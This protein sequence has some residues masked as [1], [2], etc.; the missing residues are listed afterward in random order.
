MKS[1]RLKQIISMALCAIIISGFGGFKVIKTN[2][3]ELTNIDLVYSNAY[4]ATMKAQEDNT[5]K[6]IND[7][8][9]AIDELKA[10]L[11]NSNAIPTW[12][13]LTDKIQHPKL[14][15]IVNS[16]SKAQKDQTQ[17]SIN[18]ARDTIEDE[19]PLKWKNS[20]SSALDVVQQFKI[21]QVVKAIDKAKIT[22]DIE[23]IDIAWIFITEIKTSNK[24]PIY[25]WGKSIED[26]FYEAL[27][28][29]V[30]P[31]TPPVTKP[32]PTKPV[33]NG[34]SKSEIE[35]RLPGLGFSYSESDSG[36]GIRCYLEGNMGVAIS[37]TGLTLSISKNSA[38]T[39]NKTKQILN[40]ALPT[41]GN[42]VYGIISAPF[43][44]QTIERDGKKIEMMSDSTGISLKIFY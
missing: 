18:E 34:L 33:Q 14:V 24:A 23:D 35:K 44:R 11:P 30:N 42:E 27:I 13:S 41:S 32:E 28:S 31:T 21:N 22:K 16:I 19:L 10:I 36:R 3:S 4:K 20:Y 38:S 6:S 9:L 17:K 8:R 5:Q 26:S 29:G 43:N 39:M 12:S 25:N 15:K 40:M 37:N 7:A 2:A 1:K